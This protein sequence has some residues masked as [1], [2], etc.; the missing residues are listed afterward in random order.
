MLDK[1]QPL[2]SIFFIFF[3]FLNV[4]VWI[5]FIDHLFI[6]KYSYSH[7]ITLFFLILL[8]IFNYMF[9]IDIMYLKSLLGILVC[10][11]LCM[12]FYKGSFIYKL[13][14]PF[15]I[16]IAFSISEVLA[17][18]LMIYGFHIS[19]NQLNNFNMIWVLLF[20]NICAFIILSIFLKMLKRKISKKLNTYILIL[21]A[22]LTPHTLALPYF[23]LFQYFKIQTT[24]NY[25]CLFTFVLL[26]FVCDYFLYRQ[27]IILEKQLKLDI[28]NN[29]NNQFYLD[30]LQKSIKLKEE[31]S[32][33]RTIRHNLINYIE[34]INQGGNNYD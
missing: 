8:A 26:T 27:A 4:F 3:Y 28:A 30:I 23:L 24:A 10:F 31:T 18:L 19:Y 22:A 21:A 16:M 33:Y 9:I 34:K 20:E 17:L 2:I 32:N 15:L 6:R 7:L 5:Y 25:I 12:I 13:L 1:S 11:I 14:C 29:L